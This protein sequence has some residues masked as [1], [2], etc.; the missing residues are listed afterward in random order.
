MTKIILGASILLFGSIAT[1]DIIATGDTSFGEGTFMGNVTTGRVSVGA[2]FSGNENLMGTLVVNDGSVLTS[3]DG[4]VFPMDVPPGDDSEPGGMIGRGP[5]SDGLVTITGPGS[6]WRLEGTGEDS[7]VFF[8]PF[9]LVGRDGGHGELHITA[10]GKVILDGLGSTVGA[11]GAAN[12]K[13][14]RDPAAIGGEL[15]ISGF[16]S[17]MLID[18][19]DHTQF[20]MGNGNASLVNIT[21]QG[22]LTVAGDN[23]IAQIQWGDFNVITGGT[24]TTNLATIGNRQNSNATVNIDGLNSSIHLTGVG[25]ATNEWGNAGFGG[26][27]TIGRGENSIAEVN[28][29]NGAELNI[30]S[31]ITGL[32][33]DGTVSSGSGFSL[34]G[35]T[36]STSGQGTLNVTTDSR[37]TVSGGGEFVGLG[38]NQTGTGIINVNTGGQVLIVKNTDSTG[39]LMAPNAESGT[40]ELNVDGLTSLFDA[41]IFLGVGVDGGSVITAKAD[42]STCGG[43]TVKASEIVV[44]GG[45]IIKGDGTLTYDT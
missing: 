41:G 10:G 24:V 26:F 16:G 30:D 27:M 7:G 15:E 19:I 14:G 36:S 9:L 43:G 35:S 8:G 4:P 37:V 44:G 3:N 1:A 40:A 12:V 45:G 21:D 13:I 6:M 2:K 28:V 18:N 17:E 33:N 11:D 31:G 23:S 39:V 20:R 5:G 22:K 25:T 38:R 29:T 42:V 32:A 34:G